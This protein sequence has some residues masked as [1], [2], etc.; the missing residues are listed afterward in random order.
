MSTSHVT[1]KPKLRT[2]APHVL[3]VITDLELGGVPLHLARL[4]PAM[5]DRGWQVTVVSLAK[6]GPVG[7][8]LRRANLPVLSCNACCRWDVHVFGRLAEI[9]EAERPVVV[10]SMLFHANLAAR[11]AALSAGF[12]HDRLLCEIQ[13]VEV[14]RPWHL[15]VDR[16]THRL[17]RLTVGNSA[18][19]IEHLHR[20][21]RV[22]FDR[23]RLVPGGVD[24]DRMQAADPIDRASMGLGP[25]DRMIL[26]V[27]R[28][29]P[30]KGLD[31]LIRAFASLS[32]ETG[33][34]LVLVGGG[35]LRDDLQRLAVRLGVG[36]RVRFL[37]PRTDVPSLLGAADLFAFPSRTEGWPN[38]LLEAMAAGLPIV[39]TDVPGCRDMIS[40]DSTGLLVPFDDTSSLASAMSRL[41]LNRVEA[42]RLGSAALRAV[43][44][45]SLR[46]TFDEYEALY[47]QTLPR[48][49]ITNC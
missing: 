47:H 49:G 35:P 15:S 14:E 25:N 6:P 27:G 4:A 36:D 1:A 26:W 31:L 9:I 28:L 24:V 46:A 12:P 20:R 21:A 11:F 8:M 23:L 43:A 2:A 3:Y 16:W 33:S 17:C 18:S 39:T 29:D 38:A 34:F 32:K 37:G 30:V 5:R 22:P 40:H 19:V 44:R 42:H 7:E 13:T 48:P 45:W 41:L 10:H